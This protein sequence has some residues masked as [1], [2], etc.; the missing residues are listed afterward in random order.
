M[1]KAYWNEW[2]RANN[3]RVSSS[4]SSAS[5]DDD[6]DESLDEE[7]EDESEANSGESLEEE[8]DD[9]DGV[10]SHNKTLLDTVPNVTG[11]NYDP[12]QTIFTTKPNSTMRDLGEDSDEK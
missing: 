7:E 5:K 3:E 10:S 2:R 9:E 8:V 12:K 1:S 6:D 11:L 4:E